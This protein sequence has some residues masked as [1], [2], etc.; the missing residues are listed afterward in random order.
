MS[1]FIFPRGS[2]AYIHQ[3]D[4]IIKPFGIF[5]LCYYNTDF[6]ES[7]WYKSSVGVYADVFQGLP[8]NLIPL[9]LVSQKN[10]MKTIQKELQISMNYIPA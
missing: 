8:S 4:Y 6:W 7:N 10:Q 5:H 3:D 9:C 2:E 1:A